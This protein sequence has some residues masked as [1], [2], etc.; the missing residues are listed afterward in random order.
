MRRV[1][2]PKQ[3]LWVISTLLVALLVRALIP[4]GFMPATDRP[5]SFQICPDGFPAALWSDAP[6]AISPADGG[7]AAP[8]DAGVLAHAGH[9]H[10]VGA[11][12]H[13]G[14]GAF[15]HAGHHD[16]SQNADQH[17]ADGLLGL[18]HHGPAHNHSSASAEHCVFAAAAGAFALAFSPAFSA[19][20]ASISAPDVAY[21]L[22]DLESRRFRIPQ[23]RG[24]PS[25]S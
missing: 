5:F 16:D 10:G 15:A 23:P 7:A 4:A 1:P 14:E 8:A 11:P 3:R 2:S 25:L 17:S 9:H 22:P 18:A 21:V 6:T 24:P 19:P 20:T 12:T 13:A